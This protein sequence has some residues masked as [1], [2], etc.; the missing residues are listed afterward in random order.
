MSCSQVGS[1]CESDDETGAEMVVASEDGKYLAY[2]NSQANAVGFVDISD[3]RAPEGIGQISC[4][5]EP[6]S[7][8]FAGDYVLTT[9]NT[10]PSYTNPSGVLYVNRF[11][12]NDMAA[13]NQIIRKIYLGG[14]P[15]HIAVSPD[16]VYAAIVIENERDEDLGDGD[17]GI[18]PQMPA[19]YLVVITMSGNPSSWG[20]RNVSLSDLPNVS[21]APSDPEPEF[22]EINQNNVAVVTLQENNALV[23]VDLVSATV[24]GSVSAGT[25][26]LDKIDYS[27]EDLIMQDE[28]IT[29]L[30]RQPDGV[31]WISNEYFVTADE[32]DMN[33]GSRGFTVFSANGSPVYSSGSDMEHLMAR[34]GH[35]PEGRSESK[36]NEP[37][38]V[39]YGEFGVE[40]LLFVNSERSGVTV[41]YDIEDPSR[42]QY[43][44]VLPAGYRPEGG[45]AI[46]HR[47]LAAAAAEEDN[48]GD[49]FRS[50]ISIYKYHKTSTPQYPTLTSVDR[51]NGTPIPWAGM[52]GLACGGDSSQLWA[53]ED[54]AF[55]RSRF[56][57]IDASN[58]PARLTREVRIK[59]SNDILKDAMEAAKT[60][61]G[62][63][64]E[65]YTLVNDDKTV[66]FDP[67]GITVEDGANL[68]VAS[69][70]RGT[71]PNANPNDP[72]RPLETTNVIVQVD[73]YTGVIKKAITLP[74]EVNQIQLRYGFEGVASSE[75]KLVVA[76][77]RAW[78]AEANPRLGIYDK[79]AET[80]EFVYY[81]LE[82]PT[83]PNG[84]WVGLSDI[85]PLGDMK[86]YV[87]ERDNQGGPDA[88]IKRVYQIDLADYTP[89][90]TISKVLVKD[91][92][93][94]DSVLKKNGGQVFEKVEGLA[95]C[96]D[97]DTVWIHNDNDA[98]DDNSGETQLLE[99]DMWGRA[100]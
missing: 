37:E 48:R 99:L 85:A 83:S 73:A 21:V 53:I 72:G 77:Q 87:L 63:N 24:I 26:D 75:G 11:D 55:V 65:P 62:L 61:T 79:L 52:S 82:T 9:I 81:P 70:G 4:E 94:A 86:F 30:P 56:F 17:I 60:A 32:G 3:P 46:P 57:T 80:W 25:V 90:S 68:Y 23:M 92:M 39:F 76:F 40:K 42:P 31:T 45:V 95:Y 13:T 22:V 28:T 35:Y 50:F 36:G 100:F 7:L 84:G 54:S 12:A 38:N 10:S 71:N 29:A 98:V 6:T 78:S 93:A 20:V 41:V 51:D 18:A 2:S 1:S 14:Q 34:I 16:K 27:E 19:G 8:A 97:D 49:K 47:N 15:D 64:W 96:K 33:G 74:T 89:N 69:E 88:R 91:L 59:D 67:E 44:Q 58:Y 66:N 5:G 43:K